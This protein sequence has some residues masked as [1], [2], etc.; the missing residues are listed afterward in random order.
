MLYFQRETF[1]LQKKSLLILGHKK[2]SFELSKVQ[3]GPLKEQKWMYKEKLMGKEKNDR[4]NFIR[5]VK[6]GKGEKSKEN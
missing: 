5:L 6:G 2:V 1:F 3:M 4:G